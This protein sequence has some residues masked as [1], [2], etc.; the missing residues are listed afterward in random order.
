MDQNR[1]ACVPSLSRDWKGEIMRRSLKAILAASVMMVASG[2]APQSAGFAAPSL[3]ASSSALAA[4]YNDNT[5]VEFRQGL[6]MR[7]AWT[8]DYDGRFDGRIGPQTLRSIRDFQARHGM[9]ADG[10]M[11]EA[12]LRALIDA[13]DLALAAVGFEW[14]EDPET[15]VRLGLPL[16]RVDAVGRTE[17]GSMWRSPDARV[18]IET[19]RFN[20]D[21]YLLPDVFEIL[22]AETE[23]KTVRSADL[24]GDHF[25]ITGEEDGRDFFIRFDGEG[26]DL[27][28]FSV[29]YAP[30]QAE[31]FAP[32]I[33]VAAH[34]FE[35]FALP[36]DGAGD[37]VASLRRG[38]SFSLAFAGPEMAGVRPPA[39]G[40]AKDA[41]PGF[42]GSGTGFVVSADGWVLTNA[43][44]AN[45]CKTVLVGEHGAASRVVVDEENDL[46][47]IKLDEVD[48]GEPLAMVAGKPRLGEDI[49][50]LG[51]PLRSILANS[52][53][54]TRGNISSLLGLM[55]DPNYIQISAAVQPG[56]SGGP[57]VDLAGRVVGVVTAKLNAVAVADLTGDI[58]QSINFAIRP[59]AATR[60]LDANGIDYLVADETL[61]LA[62]VPDTTAKVQ[63]A[64]LPIVCLGAN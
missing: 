3:E 14:H 59:D 64:I 26:D 49:L 56:N 39:D 51:Y 63:D 25:V 30:E 33:S 29:A 7:L 27:R 58:P 41:A 1:R 61:E 54:V 38:E 21:G 28:G 45:A 53:N 37:L 13:S 35:P 19:V 11:N 10:V 42:D 9:P 5:D 47:L 40:D 57:V 48:L 34:S 15:G 62:S 55:N 20:E 60:F 2:L 18:E 43:H 4:A 44:V 6:Q 23:G 32:Y 8:G 17:V 46:A 22:S 50:A 31:E 36:M 24:L 12:F 16:G 52:L